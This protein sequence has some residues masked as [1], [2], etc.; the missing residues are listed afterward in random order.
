MSEPIITDPEAKANLAAFQVRRDMIVHEDQLINARLTALLLA[1]SFLITA[2]VIL[3]ANAHHPGNAPGFYW[4]TLLISGL[5]MLLGVLTNHSIAAAQL[6]QSYVRDAARQYEKVFPF[7]GSSAPEWR[8][9]LQSHTVLTLHAGFKIASWLPKTTTIAWVGF[10]YYC[11]DRIS[12]WQV[13]AST[14]IG[15]FLAVL[16]AFGYV[17][18]RMWTADKAARGA[19][20]A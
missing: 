1:Q 18:L 17:Y 5:S 11:V 3:L 8:L 10:V 4:L 12:G 20:T 16:A 2:A 13:A 7:G 19:A 6:A 15:T 9:C 14:S